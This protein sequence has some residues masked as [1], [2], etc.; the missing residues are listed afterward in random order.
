MLY[1]PNILGG[2]ANVVS[3]KP[4]QPLE[5]SARIATEFDD[6][7][8]DIEQCIVGSLGG[9]SGNWYGHIT[10]SYSNSDGYRLP[11]DFTPVA[12]QNGGDRENADSHDSVISAKIGYAPNTED[13]FALSYYRH[14]AIF[15]A[16]AAAN[17][18]T[19]SWNTSCRRDAISPCNSVAQPMPRS[20]CRSPRQM[21]NSPLLTSRQRRLSAAPI[22][23]DMPRSR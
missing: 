6:H 5:A 17:G 15:K 23:R 16:H 8:K 10:A 9:I 19:R 1:G 11:H 4:S 7:F 18:R 22:V 3:R 12:A 13:E 14:H 21:G 20:S 2:A